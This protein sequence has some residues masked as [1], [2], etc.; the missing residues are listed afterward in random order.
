MVRAVMGE[1]I[2]SKAGRRDFLRVRLDTL[3]PEE[4]A[5]VGAPY[6][7]WLTG[8]QSS[9]AVSSVLKATGLAI[10][11]PE[12]SDIA[13]GAQADVILTSGTIPIGSRADVDSVGKRRILG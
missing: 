11:E 6:R 12:V 1:P 2:G 8:T 7:A 10:V 3:S 9:G 5:R 4:T 13:I